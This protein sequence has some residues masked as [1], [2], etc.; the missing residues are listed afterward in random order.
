MTLQD[1]IHYF[2]VGAGKRYFRLILICLII[3]A[4]AVLYLFRGWQ[5]F[6]APEAMDAAQLA[7]NIANGKGY[8][9]LDIRPLSLYLV[10]EHNEKKG[11]SSMPPN[12]LPDFAEV[13]TAHPDLANAPVYPLLLAG[14]MKI[15]PFHFSTDLKSA[16]WA[17]NGYFWRYQPDF[18]IGLFNLALFMACVLVAF[19]I[20]RKIFDPF[21]AQLSAVLILGCAVLWR[22]SASGLS[23]MLLL[24]IFLGLVWCIIRIEELARDANPDLTRVLGW[25]AA[26]G[27]VTGIGGLTRYGF[28]WTIFPVVL[29]VIFF[30]GSRRWLNAGVAFGVF[31][32]LLAPWIVRNVAESG[33][34]FGTAGYAIFDGTELS[35]ILPIERSLHP[36]LTGALMPWLYWHKLT[37]N[38]RP[39]FESDLFKLGSSWASVLFF[40]GLMLRFKRPAVRR[41]RYFL[42]M[43]LAMFM[44]VQALG[45]TWLS[46][47]SPDINSENLLVLVVPLVIIYGTA[48]FLVLLDQMVLPAKQLRYIIIGLFAVLCCL[49]LF[50][51]LWFRSYPLQYPPYYPPD[52]ERAAAWMKP[53]E[54]MMSD[55]PWAVAW[56]G[57]HQCVWLTANDDDQFYA[58][59]DYIKPVN[60]LYLTMRTMDGKLISDCLHT[61]KDSW[62]RFVLDALTRNKVPVGFPLSH[63]PSGSAALM[64]GMFLT[65]SDRWKL[66]QLPGQ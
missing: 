16:F 5:N 63:A 19:F 54:L 4:L 53:N 3:V 59:N 43:C 62:G 33:T 42:M 44:L 60:A 9:T 29:F 18:L 34:P 49:P 57:Q 14:L 51:A 2:E 11:A 47:E 10:Q 6:S 17:N 66:E 56:Y 32:L 15:L 45:R 39:M 35:P 46:D 28:G 23:T 48:F 50:S 37:A 27:L 40:A 38:L 52:I 30:G 21:V 41:V 65:D 58:L 36:S 64:S 7:R 25:S 24:L 13:K 55:S 8:T 22:F 1:T 12:G 26:A 20:A 31:A 61:G